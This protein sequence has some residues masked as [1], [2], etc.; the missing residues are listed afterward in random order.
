MAPSGGYE[1][2]AHGATLVKVP[3]TL[4]LDYGGKYTDDA[5]RE[6]VE[7]HMTAGEYAIIKLDGVI[8]VWGSG[9]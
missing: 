2:P 3:Y 1:W 7:K 5:I 8:P 4:H 9:P 6:L